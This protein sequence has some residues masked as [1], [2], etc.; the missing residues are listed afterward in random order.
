M[1]TPKGRTLS[2][3]AGQGESAQATDEYE[4]LVAVQG[5]E[6][7]PMQEEFN[8]AMNMT[9]ACVHASFDCFRKIDSN[10]VIYFQC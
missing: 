6:V 4:K 1:K 7:S 5:E 9:W 8:K 3:A 2:L 10:D